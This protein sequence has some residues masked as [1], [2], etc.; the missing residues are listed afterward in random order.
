MH[1]CTH[2]HANVCLRFGVYEKKTLPSRATDAD[3][4]F[5]ALFAFPYHGPET[6]VLLLLDQSAVGDDVL[7][8]KVRTV[9][10]HSVLCEQ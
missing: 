3:P 10:V 7:L 8:G 4:L 1:M 9:H 2:W 5:N 6:L